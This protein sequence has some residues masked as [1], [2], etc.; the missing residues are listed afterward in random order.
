MLCLVDAVVRNSYDFVGRSKYWETRRRRI[1]WCDEAAGA[2]RVCHGCGDMVGCL[3][4]LVCCPDGAGCILLVELS[5]AGDGH[6]E[7]YM[8]GVIGALCTGG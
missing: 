8:V 6:L 5:C 1:S 2:S 7:V 3:E 4:V